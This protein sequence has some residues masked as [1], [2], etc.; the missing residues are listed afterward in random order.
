MSWTVA[1]AILIGMIFKFLN[2]PPS[3]MV[4]W[5]LDK[6]ALHPQLDPKDA[7]ITYNGNQ[8]KGEEK[9]RF[10][11]NFNKASFLEEYWIYPGNEKLFLNPDI[12]VIPYVI[13]LKRRNK[14]V[15][16]FVYQY[17]EH[18]DV[19]KQYK[20]KVKSYSLRSHDL[21]VNTVSSDK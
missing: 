17:D 18:I 15:N 20:K 19:V 13:N 5:F 2:A 12:N 6:F 9:I 21:Q 4:G 8:L 11:E 16:L 10:I 7:T 1:I 14:A 3:A